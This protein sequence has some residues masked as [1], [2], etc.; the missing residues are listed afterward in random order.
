MNHRPKCEKQNNNT[1]RRKES[2]FIYTRIG[3]SL[4]KGSQKSLKE[5]I[6]KLDLIKMN[7]FCSLKDT[8]NTVQKQATDWKKIFAAHIFKQ[9]TYTQNI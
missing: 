7:K 5:N 8:I 1:I 9:M 2:I 6:D 4:L 3:K